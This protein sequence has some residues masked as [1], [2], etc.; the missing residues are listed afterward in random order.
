MGQSCFTTEEPVIICC[1][2]PFLKAIQFPDLSGVVNQITTES[3][4]D[5]IN[6][7]DIGYTSVCMTG[8]IDHT[9]FC[10]SPSEGI[11]LR[12]AIGGGDRLGE[13]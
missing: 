3:V 7:D 8:C 2:S 1:L 9:N 11:A 6:F 5:S 13:H 10:V 12:I 4:A